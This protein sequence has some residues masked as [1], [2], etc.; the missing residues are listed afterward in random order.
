MGSATNYRIRQPCARTPYF[1]HPVAAPL[2]IMSR[3]AMVPNC[4]ASLNSAPANHLSMS[5]ITRPDTYT[6]KWDERYVKS[7]EQH[8]RPSKCFPETP[9]NSGKVGVPQPIARPP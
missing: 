1:T 4:K 9:V 5:S 2:N 8:Y 7:Y 6:S 3:D